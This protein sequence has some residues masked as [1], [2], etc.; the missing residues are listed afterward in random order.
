[1]HLERAGCGC[2]RGTGIV[3][4]VRRATVIPVVAFSDQPPTPAHPHRRR[5]AVDNSQ[6]QRGEPRTK[7]GLT[8]RR[9]AECTPCL[10]SNTRAPATHPYSADHSHEQRGESSSQM[11]AASASPWHPSSPPLL[12]ALAPLPALR[13]L[14]ALLLLLVLVLGR[15]ESQ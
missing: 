4:G 11:R 15:M 7:C 9:K 5:R 8:P 2:P 12:C 10:A 14:G 6:W 13:P 1:M 3:A